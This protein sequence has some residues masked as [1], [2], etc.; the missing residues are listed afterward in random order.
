MNVFVT[1]ASGVI[2]Q[3]VIPQL[4]AAGHAVTAVARSAEQAVAL[5]QARA[6]PLSLD[7]FDRPALRA[8][9]AG[10]EAVINLATHIPASVWRMLVLPGAWRENDR[11]RKIASAGLVDAALAAGVGCFLQESFAPVYPDCG[12]TW[13]DERV[14][15]RPARYNRT[16][17]DAEAAARRF[18][19]SGG[20]GIVLRFASFYGPDAFQTLAMIEAVRAGWAPLPGAPEAFYSSISHDDAA[21]AVVAALGAPAGIYNVADDEPLRRRDCAD[22]LA[23]ALGV[24]M[25]KFPPLWTVRLFGSLGALMARS[26]RISNRKLRAASEWVPIYPSVR[27]GWRATL[28]A[29]G[30]PTQQRY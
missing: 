6:R 11:L 24:G 5:R 2:G 16:V 27:E 22:S 20:T 28:D 26:Q 25:P 10:Q 12:D 21:R 8:A 1:G 15:I 17:A 18:T 4:V 7:L 19:E 23:A 3:R 29:L 14:P 30:D 13:I 9:L